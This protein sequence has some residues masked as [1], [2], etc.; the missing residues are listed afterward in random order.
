MKK[1]VQKNSKLIFILI[2]L[3]FLMFLFMGNISAE[4]CTIKLRSICNVNGDYSIMGLSYLTNAHGELIEQNNYENVLCCDFGF[5]N[6]TCDDGGINKL[7]G[8]SDL[9]NAHAEIPNLNNYANDMCYDGVKNCVAIDADAFCS[10]LDLTRIITLSSDTNAHLGDYSTSLEKKICCEINPVG[11]LCEIK[12]NCE[13]GLICDDGQCVTPITEVYWAL[14]SNP[15]KAIYDLQV[16]VGSTEVL[17]MLKF[18]GLYDG[19]LVD[20][21]IYEQDVF[22][23]KIKTVS[24]VAVDGEGNANVSWTISEA[25]IEEASKSFVEG[26]LEYFYFKVEDFTSNEL[27][28]T[29]IECEI[30]NSCGDYDNNISC[31]GDACAKASS[32]LCD[33]DPLIDCWCAWDE[34]E[35]KCNTV[36]GE[37]TTEEIYCGYCGDNM[38]NLSWEGCDDG[39]HIDGDGCSYG[40]IV[41]DEGEWC[42]DGVIN[43][44]WEE[45]DDDNNADGDGCSKSCMVEDEGEWCGDGV[46]NQDWEECDDSNNGWNADLCSPTCQL[47][48]VNCDEIEIPSGAGTCSITE[49]TD[50][51]CDDGFITYSWEG[52]WSGDLVGSVYEKCV[53][54]GT[55][56]VPC[57]AQIALPFFGFYNVVITIIVIAL[58]YVFLST[59]KK[60]SKKV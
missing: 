48:E 5:G 35:S 57:P 43:Q 9:T 31:G 13:A 20:F 34:T 45:C 41:E 53:A 25:D 46:I 60:K 29:T 19:T 18:S 15:S 7:L 52:T 24:N 21:E 12:E 26:E 40:C 32:P 4:I 11:S 17:L 55:R 42:G 28:I 39:A 51:D 6:T 22:G 23:G 47:Q 49:I 10:S 50:D 14:P 16:D 58:V 56:T 27:I 30:I 2:S 36:A 59:K 3:L 44:D 38:V 8:L 54:G 33:D 1:S 37:I